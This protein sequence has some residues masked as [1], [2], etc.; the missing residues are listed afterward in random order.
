MI[1]YFT[2]TGNSLY[3]ARMLNDGEP[4][5]IAQ[6]VHNEDKKYRAERI[7]VVCPVYGHEMPQLVKEF[8]SSGTFDTEYFYLILTYGARHGGAAELAAG[9]LKTTQISPAYI[10]TLL[11]V[12]NFLPVFDMNEEMKLDKDVDENL[13]KL[14]DDIHMGVRG[15]SEVTDE[16]RA[17][18]AQFV[19]MASKMPAFAVKHMYR[20]TGKCVSCGTCIKVCPKGC[21]SLGARKAEWSYEG[22]IGCMACIHA[23][24]SKAIRLNMPEKNAKAR[25]R[26]PHVPL[27]DIIRANHQ[28]E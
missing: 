27:A 14:R 10:A 16:D 6:A 1:F 8:L 3:A 12:D 17:V 21:Y 28:T 7:G 26:N 11:M 13:Q 18:H 4:I 5:S 15:I 22:C 19:K 9:F 23:C 24:P 20:V 2:A 25:Y